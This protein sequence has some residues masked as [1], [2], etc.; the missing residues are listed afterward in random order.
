MPEDL[1]RVPFRGE[2]FC[3]GL[4]RCRRFLLPNCDPSIFH[5]E[6]TVL[7]GSTGGHLV[8]FIR[9]WF[10]RSGSSTDNVFWFFFQQ[11]ISDAFADLDDCHPRCKPDKCGTWERTTSPPSSYGVIS[12][13]DSTTWPSANRE[14]RRPFS[15]PPAACNHCGWKVVPPWTTTDV[16]YDPGFS[17]SRTPLSIELGLHPP[18]QPPP[19]TAA[20][21]WS[22][23]PLRQLRSPRS[24]SMPRSEVLLP[25]GHHAARACH[26]Y[27]LE[28]ALYPSMPEKTCWTEHVREPRRRRSSLPSPPPRQSRVSQDSFAWDRLDHFGPKL[29]DA[30]L[31]H[32]A[33]SYG[34]SKRFQNGD[35]MHWCPHCHAFMQF[36]DPP[37]MD[38]YFRPVS[39]GSKPPPTSREMEQRMHNVDF[40][41]CCVLPE[42]EP[43]LPKG[44]L[45]ESAAS[46]VEQLSAFVATL[47][48]QVKSFSANTE[49]DLQNESLTDVGH[50]QTASPKVMTKPSGSSVVLKNED[51]VDDVFQDDGT[52]EHALSCNSVRLD[53]TNGRDIVEKPE[54]LSDASNFHKDSADVNNPTG[55]CKDSINGER[56]NVESCEPLNT[57]VGQDDSNGAVK[58]PTPD[59]EPQ[60]PVSWSNFSGWCV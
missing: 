54:A 52:V 59:S 27:P 22:D 45:S 35:M 23:T 9:A 18:P 43:D 60:P 48:D 47:V 8:S 17:V 11:E 7:V 21:A 38:T 31:P 19:R 30:I 57:V 25:N 58:T 3:K 10:L 13:F 32:S 29:G 16:F 2:I 39:D 36:V 4:C 50:Q 6:T 24:S 46:A 40:S 49:F 12:E 34:Y 20:S 26:S 14:S 15:R 41:D 1:N 37:P 56:Q 5:Q 42:I 55:S 28:H 53:L 33:R 51:F 44:A